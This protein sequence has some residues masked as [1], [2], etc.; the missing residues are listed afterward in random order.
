[1]LGVL[2]INGY[3]REVTSLYAL[4]YFQELTILDSD[5]QK[6]KHMKSK[7]RMQITEFPVRLSQHERVLR[8]IQGMQSEKFSFHKCFRDTGFYP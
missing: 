5:F 6:A 7:N 4:F 1:M 8:E 2:L 3:F